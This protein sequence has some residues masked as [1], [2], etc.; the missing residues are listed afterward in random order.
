[1]EKYYQKPLNP[2]KKN[3]M[4]KHFIFLY[5]LGLLAIVLSVSYALADAETYDI[6]L[7]IQEL[8]DEYEAKQDQI[9]QIRAEMHKLHDQAELLR[10][11]R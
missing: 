5:L 2:S 3:P 1:M 7:W 11:F 6:N 4:K 8:Q 10:S 9:D